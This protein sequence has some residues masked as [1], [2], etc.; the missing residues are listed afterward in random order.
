MKNEIAICD[1]T[2][3]DE[4]FTCNLRELCDVCDMSRD[5]ILEMINEGLITPIGTYRRKW[6]FSYV[7]IRRLQ[8]AQRLRRDLGI[9]IPG[10]ALVL[11][12]LEE[13]EGLRRK[14]RR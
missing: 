8:T 14:Q 9:N 3:L 13:L 2:L 11:V 6:R 1:C 5:Q 4:D 7:Q 12:L 10:A